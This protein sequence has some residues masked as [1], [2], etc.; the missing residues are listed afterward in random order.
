MDE[1]F[2]GYGRSDSPESTRDWTD[3]YPEE[4]KMSNYRKL[5][6]QANK[7]R[8]GLWESMEAARFYLQACQA[9]GRECECGACKARD[10][11]LEALHE[12]VFGP[13]S[14]LCK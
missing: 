10:V 3:E 12:Y 14:G 5:Y 8:H 11:I 9:H 13:D 6:E 4:D 7:Q 2:E 1:T